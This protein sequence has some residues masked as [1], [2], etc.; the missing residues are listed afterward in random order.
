[1][2]DEKRFVLRVNETKTWEV[3][4]HAESEEEAKEQFK[5][6]GVRDYHHYV[7]DDLIESNTTIAS[8]YREEN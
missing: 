3:V 2:E 5:D 6:R 4:I 7:S 1:M 8:I